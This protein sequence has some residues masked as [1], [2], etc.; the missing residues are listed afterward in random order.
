MTETIETSLAD[1]IGRVSLN[2]PD[3][4]NALTTDMLRR[5]ADAVRD[6]DAEPD[7]RLIVWEGRGDKGFSAGADLAEFS[8]GVAHLEENGAATAAL[9]DAVDAASTPILALAHGRCLGAGAGLLCLAD[10]VIA[11]DNLT[12]GFPEML[13][14]MYPAAV[15]ALALRRVPTNLARQL[16]ATG[17]NIGAHEAQ[18]LGFVSEVLPAENYAEES[19]ARVAF[20]AERAAGLDFARR[21]SAAGNN[22]TTAELLRRLSPL[23]IENYESP[24]VADAVRAY[25]ARLG[26]KS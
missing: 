23:V 5:L 16:C 21:V 3:K 17:R 1:G 20:Y 10:I 15:H 26:G 11:N 24:G 6:L 4:A 19:E 12:F 2:R 18:I 14:G 22:G 25:L 13:F 7:C 9:A 8:G